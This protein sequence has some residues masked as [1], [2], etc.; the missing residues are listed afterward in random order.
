MKK[1]LL[2]FSGLLLAS[3]AFGQT[4]TP[5]ADELAV[6]A[7]IEDYVEG[8]YQ[9]DSSRIIKSVHPDLR[10]IGYW[11][12]KKN[13]VYHD[14]LEMTHQELVSLAARWNSSGKRADEN[15][16]KEIV[17][18]EVNDKTAIAKLTAVW[19]VDYFQLAKTGGKWVI[20]NVIWQ[21]I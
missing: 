7:A 13:K 15:S 20:M 14:N 10:K 9:A 21:S 4:S 3:L 18:F 12:D 6:K 11:Y 8:L 1:Y 5:Q 2:L 19:G 17:I 16:P